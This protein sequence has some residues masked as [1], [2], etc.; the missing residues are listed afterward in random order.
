M[1][2]TYLYYYKNEIVGYI[3][4]C[5]NSA[6]FDEDQVDTI[7]KEIVHRDIPALKVAWLGVHKN[8]R[9]RDIGK[10]MMFSAVDVALRLASN[11][12]IRIITLDTREGLIDY[13]KKMGFKVINRETKERSHPVMY[14]DLMKDSII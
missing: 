1:A 6:R 5:S 10:F 2:V 14:F 7:D 12:G 13:F 9:K 3:T 11:I 8:F 4:L